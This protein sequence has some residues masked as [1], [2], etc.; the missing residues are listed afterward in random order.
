MPVRVDLK[1]VMVSM[2][3]APNTFPTVITALDKDAPKLF[4]SHFKDKGMGI[5]RLKA[6]HDALGEDNLAL[7]FES[8]DEKAVV[9]LLKKVDPN[10]A[11][12]EPTSDLVHL[13][14]IASG[15]VTPTP[16]PDSPRK[17]TAPRSKAPLTRA[18]ADKAASAK[19]SGTRPT[20]ASG[21]DAGAPA[22][23]SKTSKKA[24]SDS[25]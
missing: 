6:T 25:P 23:R 24:A 13:K 20:P 7:L 12:G 4:A 2:I 11:A 14:D 15:R 1:S 9:A 5:D 8:L 22:K 17:A 10:K 19:G 3:Q 16:K 18:G 21:S